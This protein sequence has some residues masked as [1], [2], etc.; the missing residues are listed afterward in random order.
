MLGLHLVSTPTLHGE[1]WSLPKDMLPGR[2]R[3]SEFIQG[4]KWDEHTD[5]AMKPVAIRNA[6][7]ANLTSH[8]M[9]SNG[10]TR[11]RM[12]FE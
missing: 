6:E 1:H 5:L 12:M 10:I 4:R 9:G 8:Q 3:E 2:G 7:N 11:E